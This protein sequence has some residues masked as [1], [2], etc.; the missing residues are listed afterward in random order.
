MKTTGVYCRASCPSRRAKPASVVFYATPEAAEADGFRRCMRCNPKGQSAA[1]ANARIIAE[2][3]RIIETSPEVPKLDGLA[4]CVGFGSHYFH[5]QFKAIT[6][7]TPREWAAARRAQRVRTELQDME[8]TVTEAIY[9]AGFNVEFTPLIGRSIVLPSAVGIG[10]F[11]PR[12][13]TEKKCRHRA[14]QHVAMTGPGLASQH[15]L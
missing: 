7:L 4:A 9:D 2:A 10:A 1:E 8:N 12:S 3:C 13:I 5:R 14:M 6:G 11:L 15:F